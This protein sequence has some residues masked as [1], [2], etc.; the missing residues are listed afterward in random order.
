MEPNLNQ[1]PPS[2]SPR[3]NLRGEQPAS[4]GTKWDARKQ[5]RPRGW[6]KDQLRWQA[7]YRNSLDPGEQTALFD[8]DRPERA[9]AYA[10][11]IGLTIEAAEGDKP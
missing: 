1:T 9:A 5:K 2:L 4:V 10:P 7:H 3:K 6:R 11:G 8:I